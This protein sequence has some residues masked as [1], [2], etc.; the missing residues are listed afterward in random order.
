MKKLL[1]AAA[2]TVALSTAAFA[3]DF[4]FDGA[5]N[6]G[7]ITQ[8]NGINAAILN[9]VAAQDIGDDFE[10]EEG[11]FF[12]DLDGQ[13]EFQ[14]AVNVSQLVAG[15]DIS[16]VISVGDEIEDAIVVGEVGDVIAAGDDIEDNDDVEID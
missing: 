11:A 5:T 13:Q 2:S 12:E 8:G 16:D 14:D 4:D 6:I 10:I 9:Q 1:I 7:E 15:D 3:D